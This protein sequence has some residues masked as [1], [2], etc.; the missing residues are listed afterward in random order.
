MADTSIFGLTATTTLA[1][2]DVIPVVDVSD[3]AQSAN[4]STRKVTLANLKTFNSASPTL[5]TPDIGTPSAGT[6]TNCTGLPLAGGGTG[7]ALTDP[8]A[9]RI[10]FWDDSAGAVTWLEAGSGLTITGTTITA[11]GG[12]DVATDTIWNAAGDLAVGSGSDTAARLAIGT[13]NQVLQVNSG[14]TGLEWTTLA[15]GGDALTSD[16]LSQFA[17]TTS[18][19]LRGVMSDETG[20]GVLVFGTSPT[21]TTPS[22]SGI[23]TSDGAEVLTANAI[24]ALAIDVTKGI[25]TKSISADSTFTFSGTPATANTWFQLIVTNSDTNPHILTLPSSFNMATGTTA[26]HEVIIQASGKLHLTFRY[27]G[28]AYNVYGDGGY[29]NKYDA[30]AAPGVN[31]DISLGYGPG[32][33]IL[34]ATNNNTYICE[35]SADGAA[36][37][38]SLSAGV[39]DGDKGD[40]T[41]SASGATW[42]IDNGV[43]SLAKMAN[44]AQDQFIVRTT[45]STGVP[46]TAT[47]TAA[48]RTVLDDTTVGAM[49]D[50]L[51]GASSTGTGG[52]ARAT[53]PTFVTP[54]LGT[55]SSGNLSSCT[56]DGTT[57]VGF[58]TV[59]QNSQ[60]AAYT[61]VLSDS[62]KHIYHP[63]GDANARTFTIDSNANVA[64]PI[65]TSITF[66]NET[67]EVVTIAI[68]SDTLVLAGA[69]TTGSRS[70]AQY[71]IATAIKVT[72]T[73]WIINGTG[74]T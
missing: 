53:S 58:R 74:L 66:I 31:D 70:L 17:A 36:V 7:A 10:M 2:G 28:S 19:Q 52:L 47:V 8:G 45:A 33:I 38:H 39:S 60:S 64:Y 63:A 67:A 22:L 46:E 14:A 51:G 21:I 57:S 65:G 32:S 41:V 9:D 5:V 26:A 49:V 25:N 3:T 69:G 68:T 50:T 71:G 6:L 13:A 24:G 16:P 23:V 54:V 42:T 72:S 35:S 62:G 37:W 61:T 34:D 73:R 59:P 29:L 55:P 20:T 15:G 43:V 18:A 11:E 44:L 27:D 40:L 4:G 48:A 12:G 56:A 30:T 1:N